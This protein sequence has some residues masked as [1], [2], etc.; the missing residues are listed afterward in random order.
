MMHL[1]AVKKEAQEQV[2]KLGPNYKQKKKITIPSTTLIRK[3]IK[4]MCCI[5][6]DKQDTLKRLIEVSYYL[7]V[8]GHPYTD[9]HGSIEWENMHEVKFLK[10]KPY[11]N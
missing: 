1:T 9:F 7:T 4:N 2:E 5:G 8:N 6:E 3:S 11:E 10:G